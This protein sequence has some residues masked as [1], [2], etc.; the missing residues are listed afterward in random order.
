MVFEGMEDAKS[1]RITKMFKYRIETISSKKEG[2]EE[3]KM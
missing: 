1:S 3:L 2:K